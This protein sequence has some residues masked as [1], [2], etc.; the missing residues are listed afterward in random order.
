MECTYSPV[1][2]CDQMFV[3]LGSAVSCFVGTSTAECLLLYLECLHNGLNCFW[4]KGRVIVDT[5]IIKV[6]VKFTLDGPEVE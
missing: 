6:K 2:K 4:T 3:R 1:G 5:N